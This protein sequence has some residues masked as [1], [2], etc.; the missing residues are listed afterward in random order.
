M[1]DLHKRLD[2]LLRRRTAL[3]ECSAALRARWD[4][5]WQGIDDDYQWVIAELGDAIEEAKR[6]Q[7]DA[8]ARLEQIRQLFIEAFRRAKAELISGWS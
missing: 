4:A 3:C 5:L 2:V 7:P 6:E 1:S 8:V